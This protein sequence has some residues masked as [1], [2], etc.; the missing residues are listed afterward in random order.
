MTIREDGLGVVGSVQSEPLIGEE[1]LIEKREALHKSQAKMWFKEN[2]VATLQAKLKGES[3]AHRELHQSF[4]FTQ[5]VDLFGKYFATTPRHLKMEE[6]LIETMHKLLSDYY[7]H[8]NVIAKVVNDGRSE[9]RRVALRGVF[10]RKERE[11]ELK[12]QS[13]AQAEPNQRVVVDFVL[14]PPPTVTEK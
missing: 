8:A 2:I 4:N 10:D 14:A 1:K 7:Q 9:G 3:A 11:L 12:L 5:C 13:V 6:R